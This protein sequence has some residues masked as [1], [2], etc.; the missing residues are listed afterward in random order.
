MT[1]VGTNLF[2]EELER[3]AALQLGVQKHFRFDPDRACRVLVFSC[4]ASQLSIPK[5]LA[6][7]DGVPHNAPPAH[8]SSIAVSS[9]DPDVWA[10]CSPLLEARCSEFKSRLIRDGMSAD[11]LQPALQNSVTSFSRALSCHRQAEAAPG[12]NSSSPA[13]QQEAKAS[14]ARPPPGEPGPCGRP[15][16]QHRLHARGPNVTTG[17]CLESPES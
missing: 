8:A 12:G 10:A 5:D 16:Q 14:Q 6:H 1:H 9:Y 11:L 15:G 17:G 13:A 2:P 3:F 7:V 4:V